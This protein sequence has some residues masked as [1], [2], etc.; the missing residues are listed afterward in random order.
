MEQIRAFI[1]IKLPDD[2][3]EHLA[4]VITRLKPGLENAVKWVNPE[5]IHLTLKFLGNVPSHKIAD[6]TEAISGVAG[7][8]GAFD[9]ELNGCGVFPNLKWPRVA[10][11]GLGGNID[12]IK[13][14]QQ[15]IDLALRPFGFTPEV[16]EFSPHLT[17]GEFGIGLPRMKKVN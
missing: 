1:A 12:A 11:V 8:T 3:K 14:L 13:L 6:I 2:I 4:F 9:L 16:R 7:K 15:E 17:L 10:W 5:A